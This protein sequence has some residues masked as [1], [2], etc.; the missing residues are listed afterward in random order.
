MLDWLLRHRRGVTVA[1]LL[2]VPLLLMYLHGRRG[3][4]TTLVERWTVSVAGGVQNAVGSVFGFAEAVF[5]DYVAL[6]GLRE[7]NERLLAENQRLLG[8]AVRAKALAVENQTLRRLL[9][10]KERRRD[11]RMRPAEVIARELTPYYRVARLTMETADPIQ[12]GAA[13]MTH[14][15]LVGRVVRVVGSIADVM[16]VTDRRSR[17]A[18]EVLGR[19]VLGMVVGTGRSD[20]YR[21]R[22][23]VSASE[24]ALDESAVLV[25]SGHDRVFPR[26]IEIGY[27]VNAAARKQVGPF[28]EYEVVP[29]VNPALVETVLVADTGAE[30]AGDI[31]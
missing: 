8:E 29:S 4:G 12:P 26:G 15:G 14:A 24:P 11:R 19:G 18:A 23:Q 21:L 2:A 16:L 31:P 25:T 3:E 10:L 1:F 20:E 17:V 7:Q 13:V 6:I 27:I 5:R 22:F 30:A 9:E 28:V